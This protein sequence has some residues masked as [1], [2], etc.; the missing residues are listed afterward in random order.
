MIEY[1]DEKI[2]EL[3]AVIDADKTGG[4]LAQQALEGL[5]AIRDDRAIRHIHEVLAHARGKLKKRA[6]QILGDVCRQ[7]GLSQDELEDR[8]VPTLGL[9]EN[10]TMVL[11]YG[12]RRFT[13]GFDESLRPFVQSASGE[14][15]AGLPHVAHADDAAKAAS[16]AARWKELK[17]DVQAIGSAQT[18][19]LERAMCEART[20]NA[21]AFATFL[22]RHPLLGHLARRLVFSTRQRAFRL[23]EDGTYADANDATITLVEGDR[24]VIVHPAT[25]ELEE[26]AKWQ[27]LLADYRVMQPFP[28]MSREVIALSPEDAASTSTKRWEGARVEGGAFYGLRSRGWQTGYLSMTKSLDRTSSAALAIQPG[29]FSDGEKPDDQTIGEL[30]VHGKT[31]SALA[32]IVRA[33]LLRD[34][35]LLCRSAAVTTS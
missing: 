26:R 13:V 19:R 4:P 30:T 11:D 23:A 9:D 24:V 10:G 17:H 32:P 21:T 14:R 12:A 1:S 34:V 6:T 22:V 20:W 16:A 15:L 28:Q 3:R 33:E 31:F 18:R 35:E 25:L 27:Q 5:G 8:V 29:F 2:L 7:R